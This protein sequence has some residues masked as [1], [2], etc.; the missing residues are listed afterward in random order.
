MVRVP[1]WF[2]ALFGAVFY[3]AGE[4]ASK[5][6][7]MNQTA[8]TGLL[9]FACYGVTTVAWLGL[10]AHRNQLFIMSLAWQIV[11]ALIGLIVGV[12]LFSERLAWWQWLGAALGAA[13]SVL[14]VIEPGK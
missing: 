13:A 5:R 8:R 11:G 6:W 3:A 2:W 1:I 12:V 14:L 9:V 10:M 4:Y 7:G